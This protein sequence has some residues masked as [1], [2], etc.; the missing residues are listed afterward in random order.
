MT[1]T[2]PYQ[3]TDDAARALARDLIIGATHAA[4]AV[5]WPG[6]AMPSVSRIALAVDDQNRP[7]SLISTL[8][9]HTRALHA[10]PACALLIGEPKDTGDPLTHPRLTLHTL[11]QPIARGSSEHDAL[12]SIYLS[13]RPKAKL[14]IDFADFGFVR[15]DVQDGV[16]NGGFGKAYRLSPANL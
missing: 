9:D 15:F 14:Y 1:K 3:P 4:L 5:L 6:N 16:L 12:R 13:Q 8:A 7:I 11:A 10:N 2:D